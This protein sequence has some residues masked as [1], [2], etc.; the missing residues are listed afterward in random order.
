M[1]DDNKPTK[2][3]KYS[4][5]EGMT[6]E[7]FTFSDEEIEVTN[8]IIEPMNMSL[9]FLIYGNK[10]NATGFFEGMIIFLDF[11]TMQKRVCSG[12]WNPGA[13]ESDYEVWVPNSHDQLKCLFGKR[14][15][16]VRRKRNSDCFN[17]EDFEK[18][19]I[20]D[21]CP[22]GEEDWECDFGFYRKTETKECLPISSEF[23]NKL[24]NFTE[25]ENCTDYYE[26]PSGYRKIPGDYC[27]GGVDKQMAKQV[28]CS[29]AQKQSNGML[30]SGN[31]NNAYQVNQAS[32]HSYMGNLKIGLF[33]ILMIV[34]VY[35]FREY[36]IDLAVKFVDAAK[37]L[38]RKTLGKK[39]DG[40]NRDYERVGAPL[41]NLNDEDDDD[42]I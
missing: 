14:M 2:T 12:L 9:K 38:G 34:V 24:N 6:W 23:Q 13:E 10:L 29:K 30:H 27:V 26:V 4:W 41:K 37:G 11:S 21:F 31:N 5:N 15:K 33:A 20:V 25:P 8:I 32:Q 17:G 3:I 22:C 1:A 19:N 42:N 16:Y 7:Y 39:N 28:R 18:K 36:L 40:Y 35:I